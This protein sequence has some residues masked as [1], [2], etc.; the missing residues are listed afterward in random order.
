MARVLRAGRRHR[1]A[2]ASDWSRA[3]R[4]ALMVLAFMAGAATVASAQSAARRGGPDGIDANG[5]GAVSRA[6]AQAA[7]IDLFYRLDGNADGYLS[8]GERMTQQGARVTS[9][10]ADADDRL[11]L[12]E[13]MRQPYG[14]FDRLDTDRNDMLSPAEIE[15]GRL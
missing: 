7:R 11:N 12:K 3:M 13:F 10:G 8:A 2:G 9:E 1:G 14:V 15:A 5:D 4:R 6:E